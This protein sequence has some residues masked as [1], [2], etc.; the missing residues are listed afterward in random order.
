MASTPKPR[1]PILALCLVFASAC[2]DTSE[3][4]RTGGET[5]GTDDEAGDSS[6]DS[7][8]EPETETETE[9]GTE[10]ET[11]TEG[12]ES[13]GPGQPCGED[14]DPF[15]VETTLGLVD[16]RDAV[17]G[18]GLRYWGIP[19]AAPPVGPLRFAPPQ[20]AE[21]WDEPLVAFT[22]GPKCVQPLDAEG[23]GT[24]G[25]EDC[26]QLNVWTPQACVG[27]D[28]PVMVFIHGG[29]NAIGSA[30]EPLYEGTPLSHTQ[31]A[32]VVTLNYRLGALGNLAHPGLDA[33]SPDGVSG[34]YGLQDQIAALEWVQA[35]IAAFGGDPDRVLVFG[36]SAGAVN[37]CALITT[38]AAQ[39]LFSAALVQS[40]A[41]SPPTRAAVDP[42]A[43]ELAASAG[44][45]GTPEEVVACLRALP[46]E[47]LTLLEPTGYP[48]VA[49]LG[50]GWG[51]H[52]DGVVLPASPLEAMAAG[53]PGTPLVIGSNRDET[54]RDVPPGLT[55]AQVTALI[56]ATFSAL[57]P[58]VLAAYPFA[59]YPSPSEMYAQLTTDLKFIC[60]ARRGA[61]ASLAGG[62]PTWRYQFAYDGYFVPPD[63]PAYAFHGLEL[64]YLF[65][66]FSVFEGINY[67]SLPSDVA[68]SEAMQARWVEFAATGV[69]EGPAYDG[70]DPYLDLDD[71]ITE[72]A[73]L[74]TE[75]C[76]F[77]DAL[78]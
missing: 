71:P 73:G 22:R 54:F 72:G 30:V 39:G 25:E 75:Q 3:P 10:T 47:A 42:N 24:E 11:E 59:D 63:T 23:S 15:Q 77:W 37:T 49:A 66:N 35:N 62:A 56:D 38:P 32:V 60:S 57:A 2:P 76:D 8:G 43:E 6:E 17:D 16:G 34:N 58:Q 48:S 50:R 46:P 5:P 27:A 36:E 20:P 78:L 13:T 26:L 33:E 4:E 44:C 9:T 61:E 14:P 67:P 52:V 74:R 45:T 28:L 70:T 29:G 1:V 18:Q 41:C 65:D 21:P 64:L 68:L 7:T 55:E 51:P 69:F 53:T 40:G 31:E 12:E 19:Y